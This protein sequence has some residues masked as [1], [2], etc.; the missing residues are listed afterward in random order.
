MF[1]VETYK[2]CLNL[3]K[4]E[5][6]TKF[7]RWKNAQ[8]NV[9]FFCSTLFRHYLL[10]FLISYTQQ[11]GRSTRGKTPEELALLNS[12]YL[13]SIR[14]FHLQIPVFLSSLPLLP[15]ETGSGRWKAAECV[16]S[17]WPHTV[18]AKML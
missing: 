14:L 5:N 2:S 11:T 12:R 18:G 17:L 15:Q 8:L 3:N 13:E 9:F 4:I 16:L 1:E 6:K 10:L 7:K